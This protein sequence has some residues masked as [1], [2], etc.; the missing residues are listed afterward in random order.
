MIILAV[1]SVKNMVSK[2]TQQTSSR[3]GNKNY[4]FFVIF[5]SAS[6]IASITRA[7]PLAFLVT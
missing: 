7:A 5:L 1:F 2:L 3:Y 4:F 6:L